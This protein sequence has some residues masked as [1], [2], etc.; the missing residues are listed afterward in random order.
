MGAH[1]QH[2]HGDPF[3]ESILLKQ[4]KKLCL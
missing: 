3:A 2:Q 1:C 4:A